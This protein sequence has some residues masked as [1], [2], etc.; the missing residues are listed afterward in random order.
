MRLPPGAT[1]Q[2]PSQRRQKAERMG[3][4]GQKTGKTRGCPYHSPAN[5]RWVR[6]L[7]RD[8]VLLG[9]VVP[10]QKNLVIH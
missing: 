9:L 2:R 7:G 10:E 3:G 5:L 6:G 4:A 8:M 1:D